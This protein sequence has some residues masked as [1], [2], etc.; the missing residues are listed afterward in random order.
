L[1]FDPPVVSPQLRATA[2]AER[3]EAGMVLAVSAHVWQES[4]G[5]VITRDAVLITPDGCEVLTSSPAWS[6]AASV[7]TNNG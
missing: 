3:L 2:D 6:A 5:S 1:G 4:V 7:G